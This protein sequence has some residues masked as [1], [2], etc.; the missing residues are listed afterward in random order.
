MAR[1]IE[2]KV[3]IRDF[4]VLKS[5]VESL[6]GGPGVH[7]RQQ[8]TVYFVAHGRLK[9]RESRPGGAELIYYR[10]SD[11][12]EAKVSE[13]VKLGI[14]DPTSLSAILSAALGTRGQVRKE[15]LLYRLGQTRIHLDRV[16]HLGDFMELEYVLHEGEQEPEGY[17][18]VADLLRQ[19]TI[20]EED[21]IAGSYM[22]LVEGKNV[23]FACGNR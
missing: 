19:L 1:N 6:C 15:R 20:R 9:L 4:L 17:R 11:S 18:C 7:L 3:R 13:Y 5:A 12:R 14:E 21:L 10:R 8:D 22:D 2:V 16:D 23:A